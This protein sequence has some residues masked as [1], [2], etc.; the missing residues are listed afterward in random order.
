[1]LAY[2]LARQVALGLSDP[3][4]SAQW[5]L[6]ARP[7]L[8]DGLRMAA[9]AFVLG[10]FASTVAQALFVGGGA[11]GRPVSAESDGEAAPSPSP[12]SAEL[13]SGSEGALAPPPLSPLV[14]IPAGLL[15]N[16]A[17]VGLAAWIAWRLGR[18]AGGRGDFL[19]LFGVLSWHAVVMTPLTALVAV[20]AALGVLS[21]GVGALGQM[22]AAMVYFYFLYVLGVF[23]A[24]AH[25]FKDVWPVV[26]SALGVSAGLMVLF[27]LA[28]V[29]LGVRAVWA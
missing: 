27:S 16:M 3:K 24:E 21:P 29:A 7:S 26:M 10:Q 15:A 28:A 11:S 12:Q 18:A 2:T 19:A 17:L 8:G 1:M 23:V 14:W 5:L 13:A 22:A 25:G 4:R 20:L 9:L 6:A